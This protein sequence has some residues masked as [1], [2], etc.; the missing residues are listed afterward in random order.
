MVALTWL[1]SY[2]TYQR[3]AR[4]ITRDEQRTERN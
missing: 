4:R 1:W 2:F 3:G